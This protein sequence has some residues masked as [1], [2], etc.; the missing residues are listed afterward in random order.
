MGLKTLKGLKHI[1]KFFQKLTKDPEGLSEGTFSLTL[2]QP[3]VA[4]PHWFL[5]SSWAIACYACVMLFSRV[6]QW[7]YSVMLGTNWVVHFRAKLDPKGLVW[8]FHC[9]WVMLC[10]GSL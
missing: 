2:T 10:Q 9:N 8:V 4:P 6:L 3:Y 5:L 1:S 7:V